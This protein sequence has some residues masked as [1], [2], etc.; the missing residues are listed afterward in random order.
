MKIQGLEV[1]GM[2]SKAQAAEKR[3]IMCQ[4]Y[5]E[6]IIRC[7][8]Q[9]LKSGEDPRRNSYMRQEV[10]ESWIRSRDTGITPQTCYANYRLE[11]PEF[12]RIRGKN[13]LLI[14]VAT[15]LIN[16]FLELA[17]SSG[18]SLELFDVNGVFLTGIHIKISK[19]PVL[20]MV[21]NE[22]TTGTT[23]HGLAI[24]YKKPFQLIGPENYLEILHNTICS[25]A[26]ILDEKGEVLGALALIQDMGDKPWEHNCHKKLHSH[27]L[28]WISSLAA[29]VE[30]QIKLHKSNNTLSVVN[31]NLKKTNEILRVT[32]ELIDEGIVTIESD[33]TIIRTN[34]E[35]S[36][37]LHLEH[38]AVER[39][40][41]AEF[42]SSRS[43]LLEILNSRKNVDYLEEFIRYEQEEKPYLVSI[44]PVLK[45]DSK[46]LDVAILR[47]NHPE[48]INALVTS[49]SGASAKFNFQDIIGESEAMLKAKSLA[50]RFA[51]SQENILLQGE[52]GTG[53]E[54]F[55][56]A[57]HNRY[58]PSGPFIAV[59][60][61]AMPRNLIESELF[62]YE[63]GA[64]TGAEKSGRPGKIE[65]ANGGTLFLD[66][67][68]DMPYELQAVMLRVLQ[69][70]LVMRLGGK[71]YQ[72]VNFRL[73]AAT[74][75]NLL[76]LVQKKL[77]REDLYF[78]LSV[79]NI[80]IPPLRE[81]GYDIA[82]LAEYFIKHYARRM[83]WPVPAISP[84]A[85]KR[86]LEYNWPGNVR[87]LENAI[88]YAVNLAE[89]GVIDLPHLPKDVLMKYE[90]LTVPDAEA[91]T[92]EQA[93]HRLNDLFSM[94]ESEKIVIQNALE[95]AGNSVAIA[96]KLL[97]ISKT[98]LYRKLKEHDISY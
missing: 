47:F 76:Q 85:R 37:I 93:E 92:K 89:D 19:N 5:W 88:I 30:N 63:S 96:S 28:G 2:F 90:Q 46:D 97:G 65:L 74:N 80:E 4:D 24:Y 72:Q 44:R 94:K 14:E 60:C 7:K 66:E 8:E 87:Q 77:F 1:T 57:I 23:A 42:L 69:D 51:V 40:N 39:H 21:W 32:L 34:Q 29:A 55:A 70:K 82:I 59:N 49:R 81:R 33:G 13:R 58:R 22:S 41:I 10:A 31:T 45:Q 64:F 67:I 6:G 50:R 36:R 9:F 84:A 3:D 54:L 78:R 27:S 61:A 16:S 26:P 11:E 52:S 38:E 56:Q 98:T 62:G 86:I 95:R 17:T 75:Q 68:G 91:S 53:K 71:R 43:S 25:A 35:G 15:P 18:H 12:Q 48:K 83:G 73:I 79:L 20:S